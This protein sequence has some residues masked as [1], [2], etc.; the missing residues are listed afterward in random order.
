MTCVDFWRLTRGVAAVLLLASC[1]RAAE[2]PALLATDFE[3]FQGWCPP[4]S[5]LTTE[6]AHSGRY[7]IRAGHDIDY[8]LTYS[9][10]VGQM[11]AKR[12]RR[13][14]IRAWA[15]LSEEAAGDAILTVALHDPSHDYQQLFAVGTP[16]SEQVKTPRHWTAITK[17]ITFPATMA[18]T[19]E[20]RLFLWKASA[21]SYAYV[22]DL[23][24]EVLE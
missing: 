21:S 13:V 12:F 11:A 2:A 14:R 24:L 23:R 16:L 18:P 5:S 15:Y 8:S 10:P 17:E 1:S 22:D 19:N 6:F 9:K 20:L 3:Q 4:N 7:A